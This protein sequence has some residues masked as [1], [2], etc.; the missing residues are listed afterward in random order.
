DAA[1]ALRDGGGDR[2]LTG[3]GVEQPGERGTGGVGA[4]H[5]DA[6]FGPVLVPAGEVLVVGGA[7]AMRERTL[8][9]GV[10]VD[11]VREDR[12]LGTDSGT[13]SGGRDRHRPILGSDPEGV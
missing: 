12:E 9:A 2:E 1:D 13:D 7:D 11:G 3:R 8:R 6:P 10:Q 5:P 4:L